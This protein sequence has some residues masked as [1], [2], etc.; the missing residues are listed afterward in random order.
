MRSKAIIPAV[1]AVVLF[2]GC[3]REPVVTLQEEPVEISLSWWGN[4]GRNEYTIEAVEQFEKLHPGIKVTCNY[5]EWT[6]YEARNNVQMVSDTES[7]V[8][9]INYAWIEQYSPDGKGFYDLNE[10]DDVIDLSA[11]TD[12]DLSFGMQDGCLNAIPIAMNTQT[13]F[14]NKTVYDDYGLDTP[15]TWDD[16][17]AAAKV[18]DGENYPLCMASKSAYFYIASYAEQMT[19]KQLMDIDGN[20]GFGVD[21]FRLMID[22]YCRLVNEKVMPQ[23]EYFDRLQIDSGKYAGFVAWLSDAETYGG[24][25]VKNGFE[26]VISDYPVNDSSAP[27]DGWYAKPATM[28]AISKNTDHPKESAMLLDFL[29]NSEEM[30]QLQGV[31]KGIPISKP[32]R[33]YLQENDMLSG[34]QYDAFLK[35]SE[36]SENISIISPYYEN[37]DLVDLF[38][39]ACNDV[40]YEKSDPKTTAAKLY[41]DFKEVLG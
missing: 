18:M 14:I 21:E 3:S 19:G 33:D 38:G 12:Y 35:L 34:I 2:T 20:L 40:L 32:A 9:Q 23:V 31:E 10:L 6:G 25:A 39:N 13:V 17:F 16:V 41:N 27:G 1:A 5:S 26:M 28:Y 11:F 7:D 15:K 29:L 36:Y 37:Q 30:A 24:Q 8:M 4:D 22:F